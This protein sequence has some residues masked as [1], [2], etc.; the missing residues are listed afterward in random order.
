MPLNVR[1][2]FTSTLLICGSFSVAALAQTTP[3]PQA[4]PAVQ[5]PTQSAPPAPAVTSGDLLRARISKAKAFIAVRNYSAATYELENVRRESSDPAILSGVNVLLMNSYLEQGDYKRAQDLLKEFYA[6][7]KTTKAGAR[8]NY[9]AVAGQI[10][11][12]ARNRLERYQ[13]LGLSVTDRT[14]PLEA[15]NDLERMRETL[16]IVIAQ[17]KEMGA[18]ASRSADAMALLEEA[19]NSR[20][21]LARDDYDARRWRNEV[22]D[23]REDIANSRSVVVSAISGVPSTNVADGKAVIEKQ[24]DPAAGSGTSRSSTPAAPVALEPVRPKPEPTS[25]VARPRQVDGS[26]ATPAAK[27]V[28]KPSAPQATVAQ[29]AEKPEPRPE[30]TAE[31]GPSNERPKEAGPLSV[32]S[33]SAYATNRPAPVYPSFARTAHAVG[34]VRVDVVVDENGEVASI[35]KTSG[36]ALLQGAA[37]DAVRRWRFKP[38]ERDG[39]PVKATG[40]VTFNFSL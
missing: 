22:A 35:E 5:T 10:V 14:L 2:F 20:S 7:Q 8:A 6:E 38:F 30:Q 36:P 24:A 11:K 18:D 23:A 12:G 40:F 17:S 34:V 25:E 29:Q 19:T 1:K 37:K 26:S 13:M 31:A 21:M 33:L 27:P 9:F 16:E 32:G 28:E 3:L 39:Q 15:V 4:S